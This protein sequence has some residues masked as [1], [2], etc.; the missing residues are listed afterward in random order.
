[1]ANSWPGFR[2]ICQ[3]NSWQPLQ[4]T[5]P[6]ADAMAAQHH[7]SSCFWNLLSLFYERGSDKEASS[8]VPFCE[9]PIAVEGAA[10]SV[11]RE[12]SYS[13]RYPEQKTPADGGDRVWVM[14]QSAIL[15]RHDRARS[16]NL[17]VIVNPSPGSIFLPAVKGYLTGQVRS[18]AGA[19]D[20]DWVHALLFTTY[21]PLWRWYIAS[22]EERLS[23]LVSWKS[24]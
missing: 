24:S 4:L 14:R 2:S 3:R 11:S 15:Q 19:A 7:L 10:G 20:A 13:V 6:M 18:G 23:R 21:M 22:I 8:I 9:F 12:V 1:M 17:V 16:Q 5:K